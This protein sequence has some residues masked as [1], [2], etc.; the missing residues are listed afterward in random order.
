MRITN[1]SIASTVAA[2][3]SNN[4]RRGNVRGGNTRD[5]RD[6][7]RRSNTGKRENRPKPSEQDLDAEMDSYMGSANNEDIQMN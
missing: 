4:G 5:R 1:A 3:P 6:N 7:S 2:L